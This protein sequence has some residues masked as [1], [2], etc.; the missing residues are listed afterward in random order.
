MHA[1]PPALLSVKIRGFNNI[2]KF[3]LNSIQC[4]NYIFMECIDLSVDE[5]LNIIEN[6]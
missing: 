4:V 3:V 5:L 1:P 6:T 2:N